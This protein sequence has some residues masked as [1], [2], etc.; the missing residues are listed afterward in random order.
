MNQENKREVTSTQVVTFLMTSGLEVSQLRLVWDLAARTSNDFLVKEEFYIALR[1]VA[2]MQN[3]IP[4]N[5]N[6]IKLN[7]DA[8]L[9]RFNDKTQGPTTPGARSAPAPGFGFGAPAA[10]SKAHPG[11]NADALPNLD[12]LD[13]SAP[14]V[15]QP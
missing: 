8:P 11:I 10:S 2:Y 15:N 4:A 1:L 12:D 13:F 14:Q 9:P 5:E 6:S 3:N 7:V